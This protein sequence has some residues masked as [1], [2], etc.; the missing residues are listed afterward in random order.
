MLWRALRLVGRMMQAATANVVSQKDNRVL[1]LC[2]TA[3]ILYREGGRLELAAARRGART[4]ARCGARSAT[5]LVGEIRQTAH[6]E[7]VQG[8]PRT[9][10]GCV[11]GKKTTRVV[12]AS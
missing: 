9:P 11:A 6:A 1:L 8:I 5:R 12:L 3:R 4:V 7:G 10:S 2:D